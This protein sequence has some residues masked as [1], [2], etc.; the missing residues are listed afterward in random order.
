[1]Q[2]ANDCGFHS[3][4]YGLLRSGQSLTPFVL[5][6]LLSLPEGIAGID[7]A[8]LDR[9]FAFI[10]KNTNASGA[11]GQMDETAA[12][13]PNYATA[14]SVM[15]RLKAHRNGAASDVASMVAY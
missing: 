3:T 5:D 9:A 15:T 12:D 10:K 2:Q 4:T 13:Y 6:A 11:L 7:P 8:A 14:L 1:M